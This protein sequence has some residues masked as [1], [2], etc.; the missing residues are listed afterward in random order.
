MVYPIVL[1]AAVCSNR[2][3]VLSKTNTQKN[4]IAFKLFAL[5]LTWNDPGIKSL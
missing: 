2:M 3:E 1:V 5:L 4:I